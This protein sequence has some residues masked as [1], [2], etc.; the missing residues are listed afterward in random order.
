MVVAREELTFW[1]RRPRGV[2][3]HVQFYTL[4]LRLSQCITTVY[5]DIDQENT[6][7][8]VLQGSFHTVRIRSPRLDVSSLILHSTFNP[9]WCLSLRNYT[10]T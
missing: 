8:S 1:D 9:S 10:E 2:H 5:Q 4:P 7:D 6:Q 3:I